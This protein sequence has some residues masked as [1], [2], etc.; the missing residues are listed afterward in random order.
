M[1]AASRWSPLTE[2]TL[3]VAKGQFQ[4]GGF[5]YRLFKSCTIY[6]PLRGTFSLFHL[7]KA[8]KANWHND[9]ACWDEKSTSSSRNLHL[10]QRK[11]RAAVSVGVLPWATG[12]VGG[13]GRM[14]RL[15]ER[16]RSMPWLQRG[17]QGFFPF[18]FL[19]PEEANTENVYLRSLSSTSFL[20]FHYWLHSGH[21]KQSKKNKKS[22][23]VEMHEC[24]NPGDQT[25]I[26]IY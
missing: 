10:T 12:H 14:E 23:F 13:G 8:G 6:P 3:P 15:S 19:Q 26:S 20:N 18:L 4:A 24:E 16:W 5:W 11:Q 1:E 2:E 9:L 25:F 22:L 21:R 7:M 17:F